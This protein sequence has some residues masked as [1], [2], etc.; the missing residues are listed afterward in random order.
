M[1]DFILKMLIKKKS[2][3]DQN[4]EKLPSMQRLSTLNVLIAQK[5][6]VFVVC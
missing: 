5:L 3:V 1:K 4:L 6:A 2:A